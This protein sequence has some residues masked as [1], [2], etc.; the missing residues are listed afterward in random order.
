MKSSERHSQNVAGLRAL[1]APQRPAE[2]QHVSVKHNYFVTETNLLKIKE[3][4][5]KIG[6]RYSFDDNGGGYQ[7]L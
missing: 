4:T 3:A 1:P 5:A 7:G 6:R 2:Y